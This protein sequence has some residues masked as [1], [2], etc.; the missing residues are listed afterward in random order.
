MSLTGTIPAF[1]AV[2][3]FPVG[4]RTEPGDRLELT[5][6]V[7]TA[8]PAYLPHRDAHGKVSRHQK[9]GQPARPHANQILHGRHPHLPHEEPTEL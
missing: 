2:C 4:R 9:L 6:G 1:A 5:R 7:T 3:H 8:A